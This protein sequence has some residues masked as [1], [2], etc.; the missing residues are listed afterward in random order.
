MAAF[1]L[2]KE[3]QG[4]VA[5]LAGPLHQRL[6]WR[7]SIMVLGLLF[8]TGRR[9]VA[10]WLRGAQVGKH[11]KACYYFLGA[12]GR[13]CEWISFRLLRLVW[14]RLSSRP[15][16]EV[17]ALDDTPTKRYGPHVE[18][19]GIHH[20]PTPGPAQ[21]QFLYGHVWVTLAWVVHH[22]LWGVLGLP[23]RA[24]VYIREKDVAKLTK[25]YPD[26]KFQTKLELAAELV[27]WCLTLGPRT[28]APG[29]STLITKTS[30]MV[31]GPANMP[32]MQGG[33]PP[34]A[35]M[36]PGSGATPPPPMPPYRGQIVHLGRCPTA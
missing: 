9:T 27:R 10:S 19:A 34:Q 18:G 7:L 13:K 26:L 5:Q 29:N 1:R 11:Y 36:P 35:A 30:A 24:L 17:V 32:P 22:P 21:Q 28:S 15:L 14:D 23:L 8:A 4:W 12:V 6:A 31:H 20:N 33:V 2:P 3:V 16:Y 25:W